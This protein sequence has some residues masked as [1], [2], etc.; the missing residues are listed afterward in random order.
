MNFVICT[1]FAP[2]L[3][4]R[5]PTTYVRLMSLVCSQCG[6]HSI[7]SCFCSPSA[8]LDQWLDQTIN[9]PVTENYLAPTDVARLYPVKMENMMEFNNAFQTTEL[10]HLTPPQTPPQSSDPSKVREE[11]AGAQP[12]HMNDRFE[13][14]FQND[15]VF[16]I[17]QSMQ[18]DSLKPSA[19]QPDSQQYLSIYEQAIN[20]V[21]APGDLEKEMQVVDELIRSHAEG[22]PN[23]TDDDNSSDTG[24]SLS[25]NTSTDSFSSNLCDDEEDWSPAEP[26]SPNK[27]ERLHK[28]SKANDSV[29]RK[30]RP[31]GRPSED[32]CHRKKEQNKNAANRYRMKKKAEIEIILEEERDLQKRNDELETEFSDVKREIKYL[33]SLMRELC[34]RKGL[35]K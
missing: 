2:L 4:V 19:G 33:K 32:R 7:N 17:G 23:W 26:G 30:K 21:Q 25:S 6:R 35:M 28:L 12:V 1:C 8:R 15:F 5:F 11:S 13:N 18:V 20:M 16:P 3:F 34:I 29:I 22:L 9:V 10:T 27:K 14:Q 24:S 31:Y